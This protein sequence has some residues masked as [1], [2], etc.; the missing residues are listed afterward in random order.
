MVFTTCLD[1][2][3]LSDL[4][5]FLRNLA[6]LKPS[7]QFR[8]ILNSLNIFSMLPLPGGLE[9][10]VAGR[11][12]LLLL[13]LVVV[14]LGVRQSVSCPRVLVPIHSTVQYC[15]VQYSTASQAGFAA[16]SFSSW[17]LLIK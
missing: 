9:A 15:T 6:V 16:S 12:L 2:S 17:F 10:V 5:I 7:I 1:L 4:C 8:G 3:Q 14:V 13:L 11:L